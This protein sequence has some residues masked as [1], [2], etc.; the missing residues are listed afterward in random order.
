M[1]VPTGG[2]SETLHSH[3]FKDVDATQTLILGAQHHIYSILS[4]TVLCNVLNAT[5]DTFTLSLIGWDS[6]AGA[7]A[8][9]MEI[10][11]GNP[12]VGQTFIWN[13]KFSFFGFEPTGIS[14]AFGDA[15]Y[16][17]ALAAQGGSVAQQLSFSQTH[18]SD[19]F[20]V[21]VTYIDQD[22]N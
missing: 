2:G 11:R 1:A 7:S 18:T 17:I 13:D 12:Q 3:I 15:A 22:W 21:T 6:H 19:D 16:Q 9:T 5:S 4:V 20:D 10:C 8:Q 14:G